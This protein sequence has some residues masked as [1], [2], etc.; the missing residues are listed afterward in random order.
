MPEH[1]Q[2]PAVT[3]AVHLRRQQH[4]DKMGPVG[5]VNDWLATR[6]GLA[7][8]SVWVVWVFFIW[9][10]VAQFMSGE[11]QV[12]T[13]YYAQSWVQLFALPLFV[14]IGNKLQRS[15]DAQSE[16]MHRALAHIAMVS[17]QNRQLIEQ[18]TDLTTQVHALTSQ[19]HE[20]VAALPERPAAI[21][22]ASSAR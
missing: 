7:F 11:I 2:H 10:L 21:G 15:S 14:Y 1:S 6:L 8:G 12:K 4:R 3:H 16:V 18:N 5:K 20:L 13:S 9:P 17:D 22:A 19:V